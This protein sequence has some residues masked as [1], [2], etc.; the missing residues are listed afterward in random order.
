MGMQGYHGGQEAD[1]SR[2][3]VTEKSEE[4]GVTRDKTGRSGQD[5]I[6]RN[7]IEFK[8]PQDRRG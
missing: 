1:K 2:G 8:M 7:W 6:G 4:Q 5:T 3:T